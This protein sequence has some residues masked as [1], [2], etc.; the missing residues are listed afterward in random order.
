MSAKNI[1]KKRHTLTQ[2]PPHDLALP[3][4]FTSFHHRSSET[5]KTLKEKEMKGTKGKT[6]FIKIKS[7]P[8]HG[9]EKC[10]RHM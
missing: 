3:S 7:T 1:L 9:Q 2:I 8:I 4:D 5:P 6:I 10:R